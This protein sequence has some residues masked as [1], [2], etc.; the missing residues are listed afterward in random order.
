M[1]ENNTLLPNELNAENFEVTELRVRNDRKVAYLLHEGNA[2][3]AETPWLRTPFGVSGFTPKGGSVA[4]W[5]LNLSA[6]AVN[7]SED[8]KKEIEQWFQQLSAADE[9]ML[10][11][12]LEN[13]EVIFGK[14]GKKK[15]KETVEALY[16]PVVKGKDNENGYPLRIQPKV[17]KARDPEDQKKALDNVP[18]VSVYYEGSDTPEDIE[19]FDQLATIV[20]KGSIVKAIVQPRIWYIAG[21]FGLSLA[22]ISILVR[23]RKGGRPEGYAFSVPTETTNEESGDEAD[24]EQPDSD[25][26]EGAEEEGAEEEGQEDSD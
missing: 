12:G 21:K 24:D 18:N 14:G 15:T 25:G 9:L 6:S 26:E 1:S 7:D 4:E 8:D 10:E 22:V 19:T 5:S 16:A 23:P 3:Y 2:I 13:A 11:H 20:P 17:P